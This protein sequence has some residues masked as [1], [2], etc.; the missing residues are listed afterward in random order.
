[1]PSEGNIDPAKEQ[2]CDHSE[3]PTVRIS[4]WPWGKRALRTEVTQS[5][6]DGAKRCD[7]LRIVGHD[8]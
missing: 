2:Q 1:M 3:S 7:G 4:V 6:S 5:E 8:S